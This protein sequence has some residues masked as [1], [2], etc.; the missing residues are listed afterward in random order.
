MV[1]RAERFLVAFNAIE[2]SLKEQLDLKRHFSFA[3][4]IEFGRKKHPLIEKYEVD[5]KK[6]AELRNVIV[7][8][9]VSPGFII[10]EPHLTIVEKIESIRNQITKP[11]KVFPNYEKHVRSLKTNDSIE[12][13][14]SLVQ[15]H[16][17]SQFPVYDEE[18][19]QFVGLLTNNGIAN[20]FSHHVGG[21]DSVLNC[22]LNE[23]EIKE[24]LSFEKHVNNVLFVDKKTYLFEVKEMFVHHL[25][26]KM[27]R[28]EAVL[29]TETGRRN[30]KL[31][32]IITPYDVIRLD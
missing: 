17:Y 19:N 14:L 15:R 29:I 9:R 16:R 31:L 12:T 11:K 28:L 8:E 21:D 20:W 26:K 4:M 22:S 23:V 2:Q 3:R 13:V 25:E 10:A 7:H 1:S 6:F 18:S 30:E 24:V 32:G 27:T 5:L